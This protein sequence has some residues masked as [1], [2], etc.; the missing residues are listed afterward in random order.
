[1][2]ELPGLDEI[3][4]LVIL[5]LVVFPGIPILVCLSVGSHAGSKTG[6]AN[7]SKI[8]ATAAGASL[9][10]ITLLS[11]PL[12]IVIEEPIVSGWAYLAIILAVILSAPLL[13]GGVGYLAARCVIAMSRRDD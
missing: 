8:G 12:L 2:Y 6:L 4:A 10:P 3:I 1:M 5:A 7:G 13:L 11:F 9:Y